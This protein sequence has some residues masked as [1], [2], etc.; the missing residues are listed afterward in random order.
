MTDTP[1]T[2]AIT[3]D[4][5][6]GDS[7]IVHRFNV[8]GE[9]ITSICQMDGEFAGYISIEDSS[10]PVRSI[11][12]QLM[13]IETVKGTEGQMRE[14]TEVQCLQIADGDVRRRAK[15]PLHM[16]FPRQF[17]CPTT[18]YS[19]YKIEFE[20]MVIVKFVGGIEASRSFPISLI[21]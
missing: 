5:I 1:T 20:A 21:R 9:V 18:Y 6:K 15:I 8:Q 4:D 2:F 7:T 10:S 14:T 3:K 16:T 17:S 13:R 12:L 11:D 19:R